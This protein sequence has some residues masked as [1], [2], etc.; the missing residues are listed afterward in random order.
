MMSKIFKDEKSLQKY[1]YIL[2]KITERIKNHEGLIRVIT[3][4]DTDG[5]TSGAIVIKMLYRLNKEFHLSIVEYLSKEVIDKLGEE[6]KDNKNNILYIFCDMGSAHI[7]G[8]LN[9][10]LNA[11]ILDHHPPAINDLEIKG[12]YQLNSHIFGIN[13]AKEISASGV[14]YLVAREFG[15]YDLSI[16]AITGAIGDMQHRPFSGM[17]KFIINEARKYRYITGILKDIV[18]N[19]Y[20]LPVWKSMMYSTQPYIRELN[21]G[22][23]II[24]F[25]KKL[26]IDLNKTSFNEEDRQKLKIALMAYVEKDDDIIV[27]RYVIKHKIDDAFYLSELLNACGRKGIGSVGIGV[28]LEDDECIKIAKETYIEYKEEIINQ[29]KDTKINSLN[30]IEYFFGKKSMTGL[31]ASLLVK[32]KPVLGIYEDG[33]YYKISSRGNETLVNEGLNLSEIM[34]IAVEF[35]GDGGGHN[36]A[37]GARVPKIHLEEFL[38]KVDDAVGKQLKK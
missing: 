20:D 21:D 18:Y 28:A 17:N 2:K 9:H 38:K 29:L 33:G 19:C 25:L 32:D 5:L 26:N 22:E 12:I 13:G 36:V 27:D 35:G 34:K 37:S 31:I 23:K 4:H 14:C 3:H 7:K 24:N 8:I 10:G 30:N 6:H 16:L 15:F 11:I 1:K